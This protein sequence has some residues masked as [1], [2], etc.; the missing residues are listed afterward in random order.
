MRAWLLEKAAPLEERPLALVELPEPVPGPGEVLIEITHCGLC[1]TDI[2]I[3]QGE[4]DL[5]V[6]PIVPGHQ[7]VGRV[8]ARGEGA[9][10]FEEGE[11]VGRIAPG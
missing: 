6:L 2:H 9:Q 4:I 1:R 8:A 3:A 10:R 5:P 11:R 7:A